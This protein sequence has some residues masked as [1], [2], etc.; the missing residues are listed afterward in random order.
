MTILRYHSIKTQPG[1]EPEVREGTLH[2]D[3]SPE[4][5]TLEALRGI[6]QSQRIIFA[7]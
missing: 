1:R 7:M 6:L 2:T 3:L 4:E 5:L